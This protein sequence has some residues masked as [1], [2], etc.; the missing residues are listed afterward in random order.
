MDGTIE[1]TAYSQEELEEFRVIINE[2]LNKAREDL[3][4]FI[5]EHTPHPSEEKV[6]LDDSEKMLLDGQPS[7]SDAGVKQLYNNQ[8]NFITGLENALVRVGNG[9]YGVCRVTGK[10]I[11]KERL[12]IVPHATLSMEAKNAQG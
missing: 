12:R 11:S 3:R 9:T 8:K 6:P 4:L 5:A 2:K 1:K 10:L 7:L